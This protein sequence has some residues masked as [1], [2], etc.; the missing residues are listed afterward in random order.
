VPSFAARR[1]NGVLDAAVGAHA[2]AGAA[3]GLERGDVERAVD[4]DAEVADVDIED[5]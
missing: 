4:L 3:N 1:K 5:V 2:V